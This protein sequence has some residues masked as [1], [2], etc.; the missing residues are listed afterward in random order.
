MEWLK[1]LIK[2]RH[3][4]QSVSRFSSALSGKYGDSTLKLSQILSS[5]VFLTKGKVKDKVV[6]VL[7]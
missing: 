6:P 4:D 7:Y 2:S 5:K 3:D 1:F